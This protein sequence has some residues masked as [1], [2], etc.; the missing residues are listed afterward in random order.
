MAKPGVM[1]YFN[2]R[3]SKKLPD[4]DR[5]RLYDAM[6][7]Y[8]ET[9]VEPQLDGVL[10]I[11]W[12]MLLPTLTE[13]DKRYESVRQKRAEAGRLGGK[14]NRKDALEE[15]SEA[16]EANEANAFNE[17]NSVQFSSTQP[18]SVQNKSKERGK[19]RPSPKK[20]FTEPSVSEVEAFAQEENLRV[21][22][23]RFVNY[24]A[25]IGWKVGKNPMK[26]WRAAVRAWARKE[27]GEPEKPKDGPE[28]HW[29]YVL[30]PL[31]DPWDTAMREKGYDV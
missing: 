17:A 7:D 10:G 9:G 16:N 3:P 11:V 27:Q 26:D 18:N 24:Y 25:S 30:A 13:D 23:Q 20:K 15:D 4:A 29:G 6:L 1:I 21:D 8:A 31:E 2:M 22:A 5:L 19:K 12:D 14:A 28:N